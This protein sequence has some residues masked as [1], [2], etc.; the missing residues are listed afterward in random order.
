MQN[1]VKMVGMTCKDRILRT[2]SRMSFQVR[3]IVKHVNLGL[4]AYL[5]FIVAEVTNLP[6]I[7][8]TFWTEVASAIEN[9][10]SH[11]WIKLSSSFYVFSFSSL[12]PFK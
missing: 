5:K 9:I 6:P 3:F 10:L 2:L 4:F 12:Y 8:T 7:H 1:I 11:F